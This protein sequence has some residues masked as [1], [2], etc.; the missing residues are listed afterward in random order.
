MFKPDVSVREQ[1]TLDMSFRELESIT[2]LSDADQFSTSVSAGVAIT[3][4]VVSGVTM[5]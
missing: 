4:I 1:N 2:A 3:T 5:T